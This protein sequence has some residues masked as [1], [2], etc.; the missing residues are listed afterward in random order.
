ME[1]CLK[2]AIKVEPVEG[3]W[4]GTTE[5]ERRTMKQGWT[6][7]VASGSIPRADLSWAILRDVVGD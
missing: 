7:G 1:Q 5:S 2:W 3:I 6:M 4:G